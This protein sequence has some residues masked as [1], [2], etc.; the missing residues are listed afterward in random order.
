MNNKYR[1]SLAKYFLPNANEWYKSAYYNPTND[2]YYD[3]TNGSNT[4][5]ASVA[6]GTA[7]G[8]AVYDNAFN[9]GPVD[10]NQA[11]GLSPYG[12]MGLGGNVFELEESSFDLTNSNA[13]SARGN[14]GGVWYSGGGGPIILS[15]SIRQSIAATNEGL[16][17]GFRVASLPSSD[18]TTPVPGP[19]PLYGAAAGFGWSRRLRNLIRSNANSLI[20]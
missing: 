14:R 16:I 5:P 9:D 6:S 20:K 2:I 1:N 7:V 12:V 11:G 10:V 19:L 17:I 18:T 8:T 3:Y 4:I 15:S 13:S